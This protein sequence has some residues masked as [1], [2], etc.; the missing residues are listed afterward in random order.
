MKYNKDNSIAVL[1]IHSDKAKDIFNEIRKYDF[2]KKPLN[3]VFLNEKIYI[4]SPGEYNAIIGYIRISEVICA[5]T[6]ELLRITGFI[7]TSERDH[8]RNYFGFNRTQCYAYKISEA[9]EFDNYLTIKD[10]HKIYPINFFPFISIIYAN[11]PLYSVIKEW[12]KAFSLDGDLCNNP[13]LE[14]KRILSK[15]RN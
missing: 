3:E 8:L 2:R 11:N 13:N 4:Y 1:S 15:K 5:P 9:I 7:K 14:R 6:D 12:D 10:I